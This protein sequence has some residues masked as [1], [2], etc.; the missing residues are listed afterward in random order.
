MQVI[1]KPG[2]SIRVARPTDNLAA[3]AE[4]YGKG[5]GFAVLAEFKDHRGFDG[6]ILGHPGQLYHIEFTPQR[7]HKVGKAPTQDHLLVF[8]VPNKDEWEAGCAQM[9]SA[10][11]CEVSSYNPYWD[12]HGRT[13]EDTDGY[14]VVLQNAAWTE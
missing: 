9:I 6:V 13:F 4:M 8:Y 12:L 10:G 5:L 3:I 14:R 7:G 2:W 11:F 1:M